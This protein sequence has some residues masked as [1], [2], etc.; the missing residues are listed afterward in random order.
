MGSIA[1][2][3]GCR[4]LRH[5]LRVLSEQRTKRAQTVSGQPS[6]SFSLPPYSTHSASPH[7]I[8]ILASAV[9]HQSALPSA[10]IHS[11]AATM[12]ST[13]ANGQ[14]S[15]RLF[16][17]VKLGNVEL[18]NRLAMAPLTRFRADNHV[19]A[20]MAKLVERRERQADRSDSFA[21]LPQYSL[22]MTDPP[23]QACHLLLSAC[24]CWPHYQRSY[25]HRRGG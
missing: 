19:R 21:L 13:T 6:S 25:L 14:D 3:A 20:R 16:K 23:R 9:S 24:I 22:C 7:C 15:R 4:R 12:S 10:F 8:S 1:R 18:T 5:R 2:A 17:P 11:V